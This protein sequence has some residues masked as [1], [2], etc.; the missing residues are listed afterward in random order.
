MRH[1]I[2]SPEQAIGF[3]VFKFLEFVWFLKNSRLEGMCVILWQLNGWNDRETFGVNCCQVICLSNTLFHF[4]Y[5]TNTNSKLFE[6]HHTFPFCLIPLLWNSWQ[7]I[8]YPRIFSLPNAALN[9]FID[10][11]LQDSILSSL[12][13]IPKCLNA[14]LCLSGNF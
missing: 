8:I 6:K 7:Q 14:S 5:T 12:L 10:D 11:F 13:I 9:Y 3:L 4:S 1:M 2:L